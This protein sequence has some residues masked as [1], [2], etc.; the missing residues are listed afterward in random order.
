MNRYATP[1][2]SW[3]SMNRSS[4]RAWVDRSSAETGSSQ[5]IS[6]GSSA[7]ARAIATRWRW[8]PENSRGQALGGVGGQADL[9]E[10]VA[11]PASSP[12]AEA[13]PRDRERLGEDLLD[14][15]RRVQRRVR[16]LED[17]LDLA[18]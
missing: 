6:F 7:R 15:H 10:Q 12:S 9:V 13:T 2:R 1:V 18:S 11:R 3:I 8:P 4:T 16:V 14:R 17:D 5:T